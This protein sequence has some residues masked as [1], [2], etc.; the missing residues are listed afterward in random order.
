MTAITRLAARLPIPIATSSLIQ[1][2]AILAWL[3]PTKHIGVVTFDATQL[4]N[5][6]FAQLGVPE[7]AFNRIHITGAPADGELQPLVRTGTEYRH[8]ILEAELV[9]AAI[10]LVKQHSNIGAIVL[11]CTQ[12]PPFAE[13]IQK[14]LVGIP[15]YDV[16]TMARW[17][18]SG[19]V[20]QRPSEWG[21]V[22]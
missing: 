13:A 11:E 21:P 19:L 4:V 5:T 10:A 18:Y 15:V 1:I 16:Y 22:P 14:A 7:S 6:H 20:R 12:M 2:P 3:P 9:S 8:A 17:F